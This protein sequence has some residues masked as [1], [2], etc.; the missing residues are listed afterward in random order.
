MLLSQVDMAHGVACR[1]LSSSTDTDPDNQDILWTIPPAF[2]EIPD[3]IIVQCS[4]GCVVTTRDVEE[5]MAKTRNTVLGIP[6]GTL[7]DK[8]K[9]RTTS[10][11][12]GDKGHCRSCSSLRFAH[13]LCGSRVRSEP[14][15]PAA[16]L[17]QPRVP[18]IGGYL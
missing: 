15:S 11:P 12:L 10:C 5:A 18:S 16:Y 9:G 17:P 1:Y 13:W 3:E 6:Y 4:D 2:P 14:P 7:C 8:M